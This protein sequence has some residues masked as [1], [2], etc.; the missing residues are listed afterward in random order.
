M[1]NNRKTV[2]L[3]IAFIA[4]MAVIGLA[5]ATVLANPS[6]AEGSD[7]ALDDPDSGPMCNDILYSAQSI[8]DGRRQDHQ[9]SQRRGHNRHSRS[10]RVFY[11][12]PP[13]PASAVCCTAYYGACVVP[14]GPLGS[15]CGCIWYMNAVPVIISGWRC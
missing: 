3:M 5:S 2:V 4:T 9:Q 14:A 7:D 15:A 6:T 12:P 1:K 10:H 13:A 8:A 11:L